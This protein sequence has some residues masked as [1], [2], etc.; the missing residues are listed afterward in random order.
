M[1]AIFS[2]RFRVV[3]SALWI[4]PSRAFIFSFASLFEWLS[5]FVRVSVFS[6]NNMIA[7][8]NP[9]FRSLS[10]FILRDSKIQ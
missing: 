1:E 8:P 2:F 4:A 3:I 10:L 9:D 6:V 5:D 7:D